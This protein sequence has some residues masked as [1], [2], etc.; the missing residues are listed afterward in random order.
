MRRETVSNLEQ[1]VLTGSLELG[2]CMA[3]LWKGFRVVRSQKRVPYGC[4]NGRCWQ[5]W[6]T[7]F[8]MKAK[9][10]FQGWKHLHFGDGQHPGRRDENGHIHHFEKNVA[11]SWQ[12]GGNH[13]GLKGFPRFRQEFLANGLVVIDDFFN[14]EGLAEVFGTSTLHPHIFPWKKRRGKKP[15][16]PEV[17][18]CPRGQWNE[19]RNLFLFGSDLAL[20]DIATFFCLLPSV[21]HQQAPCF[22]SMR[23]GY[24]GAFPSD[25][26]ATWTNHLRFKTLT[27]CLPV[28][29][30]VLKQ[31][32]HIHF[33]QYIYIYTYIR[34]YTSMSSLQMYTSLGCYFGHLLHLSPGHMRIR[35]TFQIR[36][37]KQDWWN[38]DII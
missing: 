36:S 12:P 13:E 23:P 30:Y 10:I 37:S 38:E 15:Q 18:I 3:V 14:P 24:L 22:R 16:K 5:K 28:P 29:W 31:L 9:F 32:K 20:H 6:N 26:C 8:L 4:V 35:Q 11:F 7:H 34:I 17:A 1:I 25:G 2:D 21:L 33:T 19:G 27:L